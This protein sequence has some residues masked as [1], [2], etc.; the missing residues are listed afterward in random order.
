MTSTRSARLELRI[1]LPALLR[2]FPDL[3]LA[4][5]EGQ[6]NWRRLSF[7]YG[8]ERLLVAY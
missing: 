2:R 7:V 1:V 8:V 5:P 4:V 6:L 3:A